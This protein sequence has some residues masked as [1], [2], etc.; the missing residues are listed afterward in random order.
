MIELLARSIF[1]F[2]FNLY[3]IKYRFPNRDRDR[4][5]SHHQLFQAQNT[6]IVY[7]ILNLGFTKNSLVTV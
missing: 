6:A 1:E 4:R 5:H 3:S 7:S 2:K